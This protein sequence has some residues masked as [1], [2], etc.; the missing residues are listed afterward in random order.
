MNQTSKTPP[1]YW[2]FDGVFPG[3]LG[4]YNQGDVFTNKLTWVAERG[5]H[6]GHVGVESLSNPDH[7]N[8]LETLSASHQQSWSVGFHPTL[9]EPESDV[10]TTLQIQSQ[11]MIESANQFD[12]PLASVVVPGGIHR[13][14]KD[15]PLQDQ[16]RKLETLLTPLVNTLSEAGIRVAIENH[17]DYYISDLME[18]CERVP[19]LTI[20]LDTGNCFLIGERPD[21]IPDEAYPLIS[22]THFKDHY[23]Y[24]VAKG[25]S[26]QLTGATLGEGDVGL[27]AIYEKLMALHDDPTSVRLTTE[28]VPDPDKN[29]KTCF[30]ASAKF[31]QRLSGAHFTPNLLE[32]A[33]E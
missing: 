12:L 15:F 20:Q 23:V 13:F 22:C 2:G 21:Q 24:P 6:G 11:R 16:L 3:A 14:M 32:E 18:L 7:C 29:V 26:F 1:T 25:L 9:T 31:L 10:Q 8:V 5:F 17:G 28:W 33:S 19:G 27:K 4:V 30:N